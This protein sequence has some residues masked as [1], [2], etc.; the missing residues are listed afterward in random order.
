[1][2]IC[3]GLFD[4]LEML[5]FTWDEQLF[6]ALAR[7]AERQRVYSCSAQKQKRPQRVTV[8]SSCT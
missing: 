5:I 7:A 6:A 2:G 3:N 8:G 4:S 1:M